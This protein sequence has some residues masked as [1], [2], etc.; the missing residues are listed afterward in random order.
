VEKARLY[1][2]ADGVQWD[3]TYNGRKDDADDSRLPA[4]AQIVSV[5]ERE[6]QKSKTPLIALDDQSGALKVGLFRLALRRPAPAELDRDLIASLSDHPDRA[7]RVLRDVV[8]SEAIGNPFR[9][10]RPDARGG[11]EKTDDPDPRG[12]FLAFE[13]EPEG[14]ALGR[15]ETKGVV[16]GKAADVRIGFFDHGAPSQVH[17]APGVTGGPTFLR[18]DRV[19]RLI[20]RSEPSRNDGVHVFV[21]DQGMDGAFVNAMAQDASVGGADTY[22]ELLWNTSGPPVPPVPAP[23]MLPTEHADRYRSLPQWHA[24]MIVRNIL[25]LAGDNRGLTGATPALKRRKMIRFYDV[26]VIPGRVTTVQTGRD[27]PPLGTAELINFQYAAIRDKITSMTGQEANDLKIIVNAWGVKD[28]FRETPHGAFTETSGH[29]L[30]QTIMELH[31]NHRVRIVFAAGNNGLF[32]SDPTV[33]RLDRGPKRSLFY[34]AALDGE[35]IWTVGASDVNGMWIGLSSQGPP[36]DG[37][38]TEK[39]DYNMPSHFCETVDSHVMNTGSSASCGLL[40]GL[41]AEQA[42]HARG[43][44]S[45]KGT[46]NMHV[47]TH[48]HAGHSGRLGRG[49]PQHKKVGPR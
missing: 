21:V 48:G 16:I 18:R 31:A 45:S 47:K 49:V 15:S 3:D 9:W 46:A 36:P 44:P 24:H 40:A 5:V 29:A 26:P 1:I 35:R 32:T 2:Y 22:V 30:N 14:V 4:I 34:P 43:N 41:L 10:F 39:P 33:G 28:R 7:A 38:T 19:D 23:G 17:R 8:A 37:I 13:N 11:F 25:A 42:R 20:E 12:A 27:E 6:A